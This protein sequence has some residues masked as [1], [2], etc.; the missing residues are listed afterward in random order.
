MERLPY[1]RRFLRG[2]RRAR[3][4]LHLQIKLE[5]NE[6]GVSREEII[7]GLP[8]KKNLLSMALSGQRKAAL[9]RVAKFVR[10]RDG[11]PQRRI[12]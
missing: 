12:S 6:R 4:P 2:V 5:M 3:L 8:I 10:E 1:E 11:K 7:D 9:E